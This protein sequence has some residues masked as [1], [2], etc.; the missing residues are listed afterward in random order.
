MA[1]YPKASKKASKVI[2]FLAFLTPIW[3]DWKVKDSEWRWHAREGRGSFPPEQRFLLSF[4]SPLVPKRHSSFW[5]KGHWLVLP[6]LS[7]K[8]VK[9][10]KS[11]GVVFILSYLSSYRKPYIPSKACEVKGC[12]LSHS[13]GEHLIESI[14][15]SLDSLGVRNVL[16]AP[17]QLRVKGRD[18]GRVNKERGCAEWLAFLF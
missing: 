15:I 4:P 6:S 1:T 3:K 8:K 2:P 13:A 10:D 12:L 18:F 14:I 5:V 16:K 9:E 11:E 17:S 7:G